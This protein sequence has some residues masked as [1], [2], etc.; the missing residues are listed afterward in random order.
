MARSFSHIS[1]RFAKR[2]RRSPM[3]NVAKTIQGGKVIC[4]FDRRTTN[5]IVVRSHV[6]FF[7]GNT[8]VGRDSSNERPCHSELSQDWINR[9]KRPPETI[10]IISR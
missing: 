8:K 9:P 1:A 6:V 10:S 2:V 3:P 5:G 7:S 4:W